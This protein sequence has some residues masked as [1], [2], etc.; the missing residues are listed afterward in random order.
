MKCEDEKALGRIIYH[1]ALQMSKHAEKVLSP[2]DITLEQMHIIKH[3]PEAE[4][5]SQRQIADATD[6][7][8]A[9]VT[10]LL[11]RLELK[12]LI[13][14]NPDPNDRRATLIFI[15]P[16]GSKLLKKILSKFDSLKSDF[17][18]DISEQEQDIVYNA[19]EKIQ[20]NIKKLIDNTETS[21]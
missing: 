4:G 17:L 5:I 9:N 16:K 6:K 12:E 11:D 15:T 1:T 14:R 20:I 2:Y 8:P 21:S 3:L 10:R 18:K 13:E 7:T 19:L